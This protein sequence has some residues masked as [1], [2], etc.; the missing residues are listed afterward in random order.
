MDQSEMEHSATTTATQAAQKSKNLLVQQVD[1]QSTALGNALS[2]TASDL[3]TVGSDLR[4]SGTIASAAQVA[5]WAADYLDRAGPYL[6]YGDTDRFIADLETMG[7]ER[8]WAIAASAAALG[9]IAARIVKSSSARRYHSSGY[10]DYNSG[11]A[12]A[13]GATDPTSAFSSTGV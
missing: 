1:R 2:Q 12:Y 3:R 8:P 13:E 6:T 11:Y 5:D 10:V 9:F 7:R 4:S